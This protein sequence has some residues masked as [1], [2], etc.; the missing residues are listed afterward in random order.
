MKEAIN[1]LDKNYLKE[2]EQLR[3]EL[4]EARELINAIRTGEVD[5]LAVQG[6]DG[7]QIYTLRSADHTYRVLVEE[8]NEG[9]L[10][11][12]KEGVILYCNSRFADFLSIPLEKIIGSSFYNFVPYDYYKLVERI[13][14]R[15][16]EGSSK[17]EVII[18]GKK[19]KITPFSLSTKIL[20]FHDTPALGMII[21]DLSAEKEIIA[22]KSHVELQNGIIEK[23][24]KELEKEKEIKKEAERFRMILESLP[25]IAWTANPDG[26]LDYYNK[27]WYS[28]TGLS[29]EQTNEWG[30]TV[31]IHPDDLPKVLEDWDF[32]IKNGTNCESECR[33]RRG[34]D[35]LYRWHIGKAIPIK[36]SEGS[37]I[38]WVGT[39]TDVHDQKE[40]LVNLAEAK[41]QVNAFNMELKVKN[42]ELLKT[43]NDLD[44]FVYTASHDLKAPVSNIEGLVNTL[45]DVLSTDGLNNPDVQQIITLINNSIG[46]FK[47]TILDLTEITKIQKLDQGEFINQNVQDIIND[48]KLSI[49]DLIVKSE[50][51]IH[52]D[53]SA[54]PE[55]RFS[56]KNLKSI[57]YNLLSNAVKYRSS[58]TPEIFIK[59]EIT[60][61]YAVLS[62]K[63]NGLG[64]NLTK[65]TKI[66]SMFKRLHDH[67]EGT[68]IG[69]YIVKR[70]IDN[71]GGKIEVESKMDVG[72]TFKVYF[73]I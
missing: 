43:N 72:S 28:Y 48:V 3:Y 65:D 50:A 68:G 33:I 54:C 62:V 17:G 34:Y 59:T 11:L 51:K 1:E 23:K 25:L 56:K 30:W 47:T 66:F 69:L 13:L 29:P 41:E 31:V 26:I 46:R 67:V 61:G 32:S 18:S 15:G 12:N 8:M 37:I 55:I 21:T 10:T 2:I 20:Q 70:I 22:I 64:M 57:I 38:K 53:T 49:N 71:S 60:D 39:L 36:N 14:Q 58:Q 35:N 44:N 6:E 16:W 24:N 73:K 52:I 40:A 27:R 4:E 19:G 7:P 63:D 9:A 42:E 5:A 45:N